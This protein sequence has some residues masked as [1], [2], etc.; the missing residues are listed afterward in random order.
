MKKKKK[1]RRQEWW[2]VCVY[3]PSAGEAN[4]GGFLGLASQHS[5][6]LDLKKMQH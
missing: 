1:T 2:V 6:I 5:I 3:Y 4:M